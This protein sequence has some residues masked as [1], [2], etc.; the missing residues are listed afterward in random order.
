MINTKSILLAVSVCIFAVSVEAQGTFR[1]LDFESGK[2]TPTQ[3][4]GSVLTSVAMPGWSVYYGNIQVS[5]IIPGYV[6]LESSNVSVI[7]HDFTDWNALIDGNY[8]A[9][10]ESGVGPVNSGF[11]TVSIDQNGYVPA[12]VRTL[13]FKSYGGDLGLSF[14][15]QNLSYSAVGSGANYILYAA[16]ISSFSGQTGILQFTSS[17]TGS[18]P[19]FLDDIS[20]S[21]IA[22][23]E[24]ST[25]ALF[26]FGGIGLF[27]C[28]KWFRAA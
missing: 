16:D 8:S 4:N 5:S 2:M 19:A 26:V 7:G 12:D 3:S 15:G 13:L 28:R 22:V 25:Y 20:F 6:T 21:T 9:C 24:P 27:G 14:S 18:G 1:N 23:P 17:L 11:T 10:L